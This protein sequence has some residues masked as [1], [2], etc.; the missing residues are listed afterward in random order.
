[1]EN[2][3][4]KVSDF[5]ELIGCS[6][7]TVY[8]L[9][10]RGEVKAVNE[11]IRGRKMTFVI[12]TNEQI[13]EFKKLYGK[14]TVNELDCN[15]NVTNENYI[16]GEIVSTPDKMENILDKFIELQNTFN[17]Q[18]LNVNEELVK[19]KSQVP[20]LSYKADREGMYINEINQLKKD[21]EGYKRKLTILLTFTITLIMLFGFYVVFK[22]FIR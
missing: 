18:L 14:E 17:A 21:N 12:A 20:L 1:M 13:E 9:I 16:D 22:L 6:Q 4:L 5:S 8:A 2:E 7:K 3:K 10:K 15:E 19:Y 11:V